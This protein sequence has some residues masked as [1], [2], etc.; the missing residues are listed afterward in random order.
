[1]KLTLTI[2]FLFLLNVITS[3]KA[4]A[5]SPCGA[6]SD[7]G[8]TINGT[9]LELTFTSNAGWDCCYT[10]NVEIVCENANFTGIA[11]YISEEIC[12]NGGTGPSTTNT[13]SMPYPVLIVDLSG[14]C[15]GNYK[16]RAVEPACGIYTPTFTFTVAGASP[17]VLDASA[18]EVEIC[19]QENSQLSAS[20]SNG[21]NNGTYSYSWSPAIGLSNPNSAN[22]V[23]THLATTTYTVTVTED[24][25]CT[26]PQTADVT[27]TV[28][29]LPTATISGTAAICENDPAVEVTIT[30]ADATSPYTVD[31]VYNG[32]AETITTTGNTA[33]IPIP[34]S[35]PGTHEFTLIS[36]TD[37]SATLCSQ[38]QSGTVTVTVHE[39]PVVDAGPDQDICEPNGTSPSEVTLSASGAVTYVWDNGVVD[40]V[41]FIPPAVTS[42]TYTVTGTDASGCEDTDQLVVNSFPLPVANGTVSDNYGNAALP[43]E[44]GNTS[45]SAT[46]YIWEFGNGDQQTTTSHAPIDYSYTVPGIYTV[47]LTASNGICYDTWATTIEV[48][49]PMEVVS[50]NI[51]TPNG[52]DA[53]DFY[54]VNV[55]YG[56]HFEAV[57]VNRWG[58]VIAELNSVNQGWDGKSKGKDVEEGV[59]FIRYT[60][61]DF[62]GKQ[63]EGHTYFHLER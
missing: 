5:C 36:V 40:G 47:V 28:N 31:Y 52:D 15:P 46:N 39:L 62:G 30:G 33:T 58:N 10:V 7:I 55:R 57:I 54:F 41:P 21:C 20:A 50:P 38:N 26:A 45:I 35:P 16:W 53:N 59:Y 37:A 8:Q 1:M 22:P 51:F 43:V 34:N 61:T 19:E 4:L 3:N 32:N 42:T 14:F 11:N 2:G 25:S 17:I 29:P 6:L 44:F 49:P 23:A 48:L 9:N 13:L 63:V 56:Q 27:I 12:F 60:A 24:G 18:S